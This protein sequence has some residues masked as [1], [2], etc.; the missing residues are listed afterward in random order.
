M[1][2]TAFLFM[3][4]GSLFAQTEP[5]TPEAPVEGSH[6]KSIR[7]L[8]QITPGGPEKGKLI[9]SAARQRGLQQ[10]TLR[11][12]QSGLGEEVSTVAKGL[13]PSQA[14]RPTEPGK[15][16]ALP[17]VTSPVRGRPAGLPGKVQ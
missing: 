14:G 2:I 5:E 9:S 4:G 10:A 1:L 11:S 8:A 16:A 12:S 15:P 7:E 17:P 3:V 13:R 6:G